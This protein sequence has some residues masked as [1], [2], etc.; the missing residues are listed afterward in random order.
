MRIEDATK[1]RECLLPAPDRGPCVRCRVLSSRRA[2]PLLWTEAVG[3]TTAFSG[4]ALAAAPAYLV[5]DATNGSI[6]FLVW[7]PTTFLV[8]IPMVLGVLFVENALASVVRRRRC[9]AARARARRVPLVRAADAREPI[10]RVAG[11]VVRPGAPGEVVLETS[12]LRLHP[13]RAT[14]EIDDG[15]GCVAVVD[16]DLLELWDEA[17]GRM[18]VTVRAGDHVEVS[19]PA[20]RSTTEVG[21]RGTGQ[22]LLFEG[23]EACPVHVT[24]VPRARG[25]RAAGNVSSSERV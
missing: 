2:W 8:A 11:R 23:T 12:A 10:V 6:G 4:M 17:S 1:C 20:R 25:V 16:D 5:G 13:A 7:L 24:R 9:A 18:E 19:G 14:F 21:Y 22:V 3:T 15:S